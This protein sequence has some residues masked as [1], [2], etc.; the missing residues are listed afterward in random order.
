MTFSRKAH[1]AAARLKALPSGAML[2]NRGIDLDQAAGL[3]GLRSGG[4]RTRSGAWRTAFEPHSPMK[5]R[6]QVP[7]CNRI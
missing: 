3:S 1:A 6:T 7:S 5:C 4:R 2:T